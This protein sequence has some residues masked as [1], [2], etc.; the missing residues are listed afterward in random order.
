MA[1]VFACD[2][3]KITVDGI[4]RATGLWQP[5]STWLIVTRGDQIWVTCSKEC[6]DFLYERWKWINSKRNTMTVLVIA[7]KEPLDPEK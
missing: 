3:C 1:V 4:P 7:E 5:P 6:F 2:K